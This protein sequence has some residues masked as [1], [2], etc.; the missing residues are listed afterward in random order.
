MIKNTDTGIKEQ[1]KSIDSWNV[2]I[3]VYRKK[4]ERDFTVMQQALNELE[5]HQK[6]IENF[7]RQFQK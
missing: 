1:E 6:S 2:H 7:S 3:E 4:L 5:L